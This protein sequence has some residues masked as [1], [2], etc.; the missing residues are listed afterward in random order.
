MRNYLRVF[1]YSVLLINF[2]LLLRIGSGPVKYSMKRIVTIAFI[3]LLFCWQNATGQEDTIPSRSVFQ[4]TYKTSDGKAIN[5]YGNERV[6]ANESDGFGTFTVDLALSEPTIET[7][8]FSSAA[9][10]SSVTI[11]DGI[12]AIGNAAFRKSSVKTVILP[13]SVKRIGA[14]AFEQCG[15]LTNIILPFKLKSIGDDAFNSCTALETMC[16]PESVEKIGAGIFMDCRS[17]TKV[18]LPAAVTEIPMEAFSGCT[19]LKSIVL[20]GNLMTICSSAFENSGLEK[21]WI[22]RKMVS[23]SRNAFKPGAD[24]RMIRINVPQHMAMSDFA[25]FY[26]IETVPDGVVTVR[27]SEN[28]NTGTQPAVSQEYGWILGTWGVVLGN[29]TITVLFN[30]TGESGDIMMMVE[31][32]MRYGKYIV[33]NDQI[34]Y[35][36]KAEGVDEVIEIRPGKKLYAGAGKYYAKKI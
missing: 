36:I 22:P 30:G 1:Y 14:S 27:S 32:V 13:S 35:H 33:D 21:L 5:F 8:I 26:G 15:E 17:L 3:C 7:G 4:I 34:K 24:G 25:A 2:A 28:R 6:L 23:I 29:Q 10:L 19:A 16:L 9:N 31:G 11:P 12:T 18:V 20:P